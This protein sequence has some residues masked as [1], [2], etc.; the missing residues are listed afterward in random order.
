MSINLV[1]QNGNK[2][3]EVNR[4]QFIRDYID[5][6]RAK[7]VKQAEEQ[8]KK[9]MKE[10]AEAEN[11]R[12]NRHT[13]RA[14]N[15]ERKHLKD[16]DALNLMNGIVKMLN[17]ANVSYTQENAKSVIVWMNEKKYE[18]KITEKRK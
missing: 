11:K 3:G 4:E 7:D 5:A 13:E 14:S 10:E 18:I 12:L 9:Q 15:I 1:D 6:K 2:T 8:A 17:D 16:N